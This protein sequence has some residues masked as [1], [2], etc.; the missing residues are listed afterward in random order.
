LYSTINPPH[1]PPLPLKKTQFFLQ[2]AEKRR[3]IPP[4]NGFQPLLGA[5]NRP[6]GWLM[7]GL[8]PLHAF[9]GFF[10]MPRKNGIFMPRQGERSFFPKWVDKEGEIA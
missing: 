3:F 6:R 9:P 2:V 4:G 8:R 7:K 10:G 5:A 1:P